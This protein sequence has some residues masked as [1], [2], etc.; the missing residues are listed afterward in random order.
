MLRKVVLACAVVVSASLLLARVHPFGDAGLYQASSAQA[1]LL[2]HSVVPP[3]V[4]AIL[5]ANCA[6][7]HS[8]QTHVPAYG[9]FAPA[10][11]L[12]EGDITHGRKAM[13]LSLWN[14]YSLEQQ[15]TLAAKIVREARSHEMPPLQYR[16]IHWN[17]RITDADLAV[18][19]RW[20]RG[21]SFEFADSAAQPAGDGDPT[22]GKDIFER[23]CT[24]CH[25]LDQ[26]REGPRLHDV[27]GRRSADV[28]NF[29]YSDALRNAHL[30]WND[31]TL[32][33]WLTDPDAFV[34]GNNMDFH[35][36]K[37]QERKDV[38]SF[39]KKQHEL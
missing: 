29:P 15:Q 18:L 23:R 39:L 37:P 4:N 16:M 19:T 6:D 17:A 3:D 35:V 26:N 10:S 30:V 27:Y 2:E 5:T 33:Q 28:P 38:I 13:N 31:T 7:C 9:R 32:N 25:S 36:A 34:L 8:N 24:G 11:W 14:T 1:P 12:M 20:T 22:R 21:T